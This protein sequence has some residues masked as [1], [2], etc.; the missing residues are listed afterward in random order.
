MSVFKYFS[1]PKFMQELL[2]IHVSAF[3]VLSVAEIGDGIYRRKFPESLSN[4][5]LDL[6]EFEVPLSTI[7]QR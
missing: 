6:V 3:S 1:F 2:H 7:M 4:K 5:I